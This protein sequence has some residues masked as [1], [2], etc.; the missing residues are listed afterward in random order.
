MI[1][2]AHSLNY[3]ETFIFSFA[4]MSAMLYLFGR[5]GIESLIRR[6][7]M[8]LY[9]LRS[10]SNLSRTSHSIWATR[11]G[12]I[13]ETPF[14]AEQFTKEVERRFH[15]PYPGALGEVLRLL[16]MTSRVDL[17]FVLNFRELE[18]I[19]I[20]S[21]GFPMILSRLSENPG[22]SMHIDTT[23]YRS[24]MHNTVMWFVVAFSFFTSLG[25]SWLSWL[26]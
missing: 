7:G 21:S 20:T 19:L 15:K 11:V 22:I 26:C 1:P 6:L 16:T 3:V 17:N 25:L 18:C 10:A 13:S 12:D 5:A 2:S 9:A 23:S 4:A 14:D 8:D 24:A